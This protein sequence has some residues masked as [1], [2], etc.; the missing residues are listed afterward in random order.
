MPNYDVATNVNDAVKANP[1]LENDPTSAFALGQIQNVDGNTAG[2]ASKGVSWLGH[3]TNALSDIGRD[4]K[5]AWNGVGQGLEAGS[6]DFAHGVYDL[7][8]RGANTPTEGLTLG[9]VSPI[10]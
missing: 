1:S 5:G 3:F 7:A 9:Y 4:A 10:E 6:N 8:A 2:Q